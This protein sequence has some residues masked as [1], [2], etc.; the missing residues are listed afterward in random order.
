MVN[1]SVKENRREKCTIKIV[2]FVQ[3]FIFECIDS[4]AIDVDL[5][6]IL[7]VFK[8]GPDCKPEVPSLKDELLCSADEHQWVTTINS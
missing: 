8:K 4:L 2:W 5:C 7:Q 3:G 6:N 1:S